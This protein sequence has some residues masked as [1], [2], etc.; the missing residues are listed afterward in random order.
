MK[1]CNPVLPALLITLT[2]GVEQ[3]PFIL[4]VK[5]EIVEETFW[6]FSFGFHWLLISC[7]SNLTSF[8]TGQSNETQTQLKIYFNQ[9]E[10]NSLLMCQSE[11]S[12]RGDASRLTN[13]VQLKPSFENTWTKGRRCPHN[14]LTPGFE[15]PRQHFTTYLYLQTLKPA[16]NFFLISN[17]GRV[18]T[19]KS[20]SVCVYLMCF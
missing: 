12:Q 8:L 18:V 14:Q 19:L 1:T 11:T 3:R 9:S 7:D 10:W 17:F 5:L 4:T 15:L 13:Q 6:Q 16:I 2:S 20:A